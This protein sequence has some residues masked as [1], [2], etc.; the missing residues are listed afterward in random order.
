MTSPA[1]AA[2]MADYTY[3][4]RPLDD[5]SWHEVLKNFP[6]PNEAFAMLGA[7][8]CDPQWTAFTHYWILSVHLS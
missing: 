4:T 6:T 2:S 7:R 5:G 8:A 1:T 3:Q